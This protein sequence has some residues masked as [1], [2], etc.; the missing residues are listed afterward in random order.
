ML[1][2]QG[3]DPEPGGEFISD[4][5]GK[6]RKIAGGNPADAGISKKE[7]HGVLRPA[8]GVF[9]LLFLFLP[10]AFRHDIIAEKTLPNYK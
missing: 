8:R 4:L 9:P 6:I 5:P 2:I 1:M 7:G 3:A 10:D